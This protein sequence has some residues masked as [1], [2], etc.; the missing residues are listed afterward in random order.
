MSI[1]FVSRI[2]AGILIGMFAGWALMI[3][4]KEKL[5]ALDTTPAGETIAK[6][7]TTYSHGYAFHAFS[8]AMTTIVLVVAIELLAVVIRFLLPLREPSEIR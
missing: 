8:L 3:S 1:A 2:F 5:Q 4:E 7:R 6:L